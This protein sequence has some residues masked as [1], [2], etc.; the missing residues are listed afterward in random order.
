MMGAF[1]ARCA[2]LG[3]GEG[4]R[5]AGDTKLWGIVLTP[6]GVKCSTRGGTTCNVLVGSAVLLVPAPQITNSGYLQTAPAGV[7]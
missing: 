4:A 7:T 3:S 2:V 1:A 5:L 6:S